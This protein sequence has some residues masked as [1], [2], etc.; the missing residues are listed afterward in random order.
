MSYTLIKINELPSKTTFKNLWYYEHQGEEFPLFMD[1]KKGY[2][3]ARPDEQIKW[4]VKHSHSE[5][6]LVDDIV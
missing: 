6:I 2:L 5:E 3:V 4:L 1:T